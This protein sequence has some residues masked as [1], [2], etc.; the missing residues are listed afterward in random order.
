[1]RFAI[2]LALAGG[3]L[4]A[5]DVPPWVR[6]A[7]A[8]QPPSY[9]LK[10]S[11][12]ELLREERLTV[13]ETGKRTMR[14]RGAIRI[15]Q[16]G[17]TSISAYRAYNTKSGKIRDFRGWLVSPSGQVT[18]YKKDQVLEQSVGN[19]I[20]IEA[21]ARVL[22]C[23]P[24]AAVG[25]V[26]AW[27]IVEEET[28]IFT[29]HG[30]AFQGSL[31]VMVSRFVLSMPAGWEMK[32]R[33]FNREETKPSVEGNSYTW[34]LRDLPWIEYEDWS[35]G[36]HAVAPR[37]A[38]TYWPASGGN[39]ALRPL[40]TWP[41]VSAW[42]SQFTEVAMDVTPE[43][44]AKAEALTAG[45]ATE[46]E[47]IRAIAAYAQQVNYVS[48]QMNLT[49]GG[50]YTPNPAGKVLTRN[51]G[52]CKDKAGLM[53]ALLKAVGIESYDVSIRADNREFV[54]AEWPSPQPFNHAIVAVKVSAETKAPTVLDHPKLGRLLF[55]D[56]TDSV[57][58]L[59]DLPEQEQGSRA[60]VTAGDIGDL[61]TVPRVGAEANRVERTVDAE[62]FLEGNARAR[63]VTRYHGQA[64]TGW[65]HAAKDSVDTELRKR[66]ERG[67]SRRVGGVKVGEVKVSGG[68]SE[69]W[70]ETAVEFEAARLGQM[71][72]GR[73]LT[74]APGQLAPGTE[75]VFPARERKQPVQL[76]ATI[77]RDVVRVKVPEGFVVDEMPDVIQ[78][79]GAYGKFRAEWRAEPGLIVL[80]QRLEVKDTTAPAKEYDAVRAFFDQVIAAQSS[81][82]VLVKK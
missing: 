43:V 4:Q 11:A 9:P 38:L 71:L 36:W 13:D 52:D 47:K 68:A 57:T 53:R 49:K 32:D 61:V 80:D 50:G 64:G 23:D 34:E 42:M 41:A 51:Y 35:P 62:A 73:L 26:F 30:H 77:R 12:V 17:R 19:E 25:S 66:M 46:W 78:A 39:P 20:Y 75:F 28:T 6:E 65:R 76:P 44:K 27:E 24:N 45:A 5:Q 59:G 54:R 22:Q 14:E 16:P 33:V 8:M 21:K 37:L 69:P 79:E 18:P 10:V 63:M 15:V 56:P 70:V 48:V 31:P 55:F 82:V 1:M 40:N 74:L 2:L 60:L 58:P 67:L 29:T 72:Q 81:A 3:F 7:A